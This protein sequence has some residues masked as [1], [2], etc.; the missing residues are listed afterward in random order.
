MNGPGIRLFGSAPRRLRG[1]ERD[2]IGRE[3]F[4]G[5]VVTRG[6]KPFR[7]LKHQPTMSTTPPV[8]EP[9]ELLAPTRGASPNALTIDR[10]EWQ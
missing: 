1:D 2:A 3:R 4:I 9:D 5:V 10:V 7:I 6:H 8:T